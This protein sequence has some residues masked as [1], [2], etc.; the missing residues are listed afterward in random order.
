[1]EPLL[2]RLHPCPRSG[3]VTNLPH[4]PRHPPSVAGTGEDEYNV[5]H[6]SY[7]NE[8]RANCSCGVRLRKAELAQRPS[9]KS[10]PGSRHPLAPMQPQLGNCARNIATRSVQ[11]KQVLIPPCQVTRAPTAAQKILPLHCHGGSSKCA[12]HP[13]V[14]RPPDEIPCTPPILICLRLLE[15]HAK[16]PTI[17]QR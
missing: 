8:N 12:R 2:F 4:P 5:P 9:L 17:T 7:K 10:R 16:N 6:T 15:N 1:M 13:E 14:A 3:R 11:P